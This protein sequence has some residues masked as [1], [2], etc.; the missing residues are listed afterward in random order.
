MPAPDYPTEIARRRANYAA[1]QALFAREEPAI[2][3]Y[4]PIFAYAAADPS[5]GGIQLPQLL[6]RPASRYLTLPAWFVRTER[7]L[8]GSRDTAER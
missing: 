3:L 6:V 1:F 7:V 8:S 4:H 2:M 5:V